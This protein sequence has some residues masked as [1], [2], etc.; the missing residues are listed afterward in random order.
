MKLSL[1]LAQK[2]LLLVSLILAFELAFLASLA[3]LVQQSQREAQLESESK[4]IAGKVCRVI[5]IMFDVTNAANKIGDV[6]DPANINSAA[7][8]LFMMAQLQCRKN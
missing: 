8:R 5:R 3:L 7:G 4:E 2:I 1:N 6:E